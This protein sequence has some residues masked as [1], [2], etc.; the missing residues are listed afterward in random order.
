MSELMMLMFE[1]NAGGPEKG[2]GEALEKEMNQR[3]LLSEFGEY[4]GVK[5]EMVQALANQLVRL[6]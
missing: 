2:G 4:E 1:R 3:V 6:M 5:L